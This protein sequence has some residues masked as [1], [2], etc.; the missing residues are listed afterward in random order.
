MLNRCEFIG[1]TGRDIELRYSAS[2]DA[3]ANFSLAVNEKWTA[4]DGSKQEKTEWVNLV[5][6]RK[7]AEI[8]AQHVSKGDKLY[9]SGK[10]RTREWEDRD[11]N[12]RSTVEIEVKD[13]EFLGSP[14]GSGAKPEPRRST[15]ATSPN[16]W[17]APF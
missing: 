4:K 15:P 11:G 9:V 10:L 12:K 7:T 1:N 6:W 3:V 2:G 16:E 13:F 14:S 8:L 5:A 17:E